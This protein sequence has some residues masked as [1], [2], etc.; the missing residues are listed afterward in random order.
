MYWS[1]FHS[2]T[3]FWVLG[4]T[5]VCICIFLLQIRCLIY[6]VSTYQVFAASSVTTWVCFH[7][8]FWEHHKA[9]LKVTFTVRAGLYQGWISYAKSNL[10]TQC[11]QLPTFIA[12]ILEFC[13]CFFD[14]ST[15]FKDLFCK[16]GSL[17]RN[18]NYRL[19]LCSF[20]C[21]VFWF[22]CQIV[23][24]FEKEGHTIFSICV[25]ESPK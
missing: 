17:I 16:S 1:F 13:I 19:S 20:F 12:V 23:F 15:E 4:N 6:C 2:D 18:S 10:T 25:G 9:A 11:G 3:G 7:S 24:W 8:L 21:H 22:L 14:P 5:A